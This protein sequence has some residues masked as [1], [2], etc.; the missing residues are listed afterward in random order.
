VMC[1]NECIVD[2]SR[3]TDEDGRWELAKVTHKSTTRLAFFCAV[4]KN[5][6]SNRLIPGVIV[7]SHSQR[8]L[9]TNRD[10]L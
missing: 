4:L 7:K 1:V 9:Q 2:L 3:A 10:V 8:L 5:K 6:S